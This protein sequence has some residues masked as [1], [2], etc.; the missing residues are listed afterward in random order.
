[1]MKSSIDPINFRKKNYSCKL[2]DKKK[3]FAHNYNRIKN[4]NQTTK[5]IKLFA[6][7]EN[8]KPH[9]SSGTISPSINFHTISR[10]NP[11]SELL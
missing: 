10:L 6:T 9:Q 3:I 7:P 8:Y 1:M 5:P 2:T 4:H 11:N